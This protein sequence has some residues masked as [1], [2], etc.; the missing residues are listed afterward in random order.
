MRAIVAL[1]AALPLLAA[2]GS[3]EQ[4]GT[5]NASCVGPYLDAHPPGAGYGGKPPT[6]HAGS[7]LTVYGHW[8]TSTCNDT[9]QAHDPLRALP[10]ET[11][12]L[13]LPGA[14]ATPLGTFNP[15][16]EDLGFEVTIH[17]PP[18]TPTGRALVTGEDGRTFRFHVDA[19]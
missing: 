5:S 14:E 17:V 15:T 10:P 3:L 11:L 1:A 4:G 2:C 18:D 8:F 16:G 6:V 12:T 9:N 13:T 7:D 19:G